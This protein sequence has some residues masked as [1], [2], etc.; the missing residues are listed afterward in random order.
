M[1][2]FLQGDVIWKL[3]QKQ[4][5]KIHCQK[6]FQGWLI[7][8]LSAIRREDGRPDYKIRI[9]VD[10]NADIIP[11]PVIFKSPR[12]RSD[13]SQKMKF[14]AF[15]KSVENLQ[16]LQKLSFLFQKIHKKRNSLTSLSI[17][18]SF[19]LHNIFLLKN[20]RVILIRRL[21]IVLP[22]DKL[23]EGNF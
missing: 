4:D 7:D 8:I 9:K 12:R 23:F 6:C 13:P 20:R 1:H 16:K 3:F 19:R 10:L 17:F 15:K 22:C 21:C 2:G 11:S 14:K 5:F 18:S